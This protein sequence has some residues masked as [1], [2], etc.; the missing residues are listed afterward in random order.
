MTILLRIQSWL[1]SRR[2]AIVR[3]DAIRDYRESMLR[4]RSLE[5]RAVRLSKLSSGVR[6]CTKPWTPARG[7]ETNT[8]IPARRSSG[9]SL[10]G[11]RLALSRVCIAQQ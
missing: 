3:R 4:A 10:E 1:A 9:L 2:A 8:T 6:Y 11:I 7:P 5:R